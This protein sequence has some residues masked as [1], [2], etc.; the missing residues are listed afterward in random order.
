MAM[1]STWSATRQVFAFFTLL[2]LATATSR[3]VTLQ[4]PADTPTMT[5]SYPHAPDEPGWDG[6]F[7]D[8]HGTKL[9][10]GVAGGN[11][12]HSVIWAATTDERFID[13]DLDSAVV[14]DRVVVQSYKHYT[15]RDFQ[16]DHVRLYL[17]DGTQE[18]AGKL[19]GEQRGYKVADKQGMRDFVF[20]MPPKPV[21]RFRIGLRNDEPVRLGVSEIVVY[22]KDNPDI[23]YA[24]LAKFH[25]VAHV[26]EGP[27][28]VATA[29]DREAGY[30]LFAPNY[31]RRVFPNSVALAQERG[32]SVSLA[33]SLGEYEPLTVAIYPLEDLAR[34]R[35]RVTDL[36][37]PGEA[38]IGGDCVDVRTVRHL[39][40]IPGQK[41]SEYAKQYMIVPELLEAKATAEV[42]AQTTQQWW[43]TVRVPRDATPAEYAGDILVESAKGPVRRLGLRLRVLP[44]RL[45]LPKDHQFGMYW[46]PWRPGEDPVS[47]ERILAELRDMR[48][49]GMNSV[50][51][52]APASVSRA[53]SGRYEFDLETVTRALE[54]L[55]QEGLAQ[56]IPWAHTFP[57]VDTDF[58]SEEHLRQ[59]KA[60]VEH[61]GRDFAAR[62]L[63]EILWYPRDEAWSDPRKEEARVLYEAIKQVPGARTYGTVRRD[64][65]EYLDSWLDVRCHTVSLSGGFDDRKLCAAARTA[66][67]L[68]WWYTNACR[69]YPD[70]V[71]FKAG[72]FFW[73]T[74]ATGQFYWAYHSPQGNPYDDLDGI[75]WCVAYP[76]DGRPI[77]TIEWEALREGIDDFRYVYSLELAIAKARAK[78][79]AEAASVAE[80]AGRL[81]DELRDEIVSDL[82]EYERRGLNF[83][84]DSIWPAE[85]YDDWRK[86]IAR[87]IVRLQPLSPIP[88]TSPAGRS[89]P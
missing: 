11:A 20:A 8:P 14:L 42:K 74:G 24:V 54:L 18:K 31:L 49:H 28:P 53:E 81:L 77:P 69:E 76:G 23:S 36:V 55:K 84:T 60:F 2:L 47:E 72:F 1:G 21:R 56:P 5:Y 27:P 68:F 15:G 85:K 10:D 37:G 34:C 89:E 63:P 62:N 9:V 59:V 17:A 50:A 38:R 80:E 45:E 83:H 44:V 86:R 52:S 30:V 64:T 78:G 6:A 71:R 87:M 43:I 57:P 25:K 19:L 61:A 22:S 73:K 46:G 40:Q 35:V 39:R 48:E 41:G 70:V 3:A 33:A 32:Q 13:V 79:S 4:P 7:Q 65:A 67:D 16:L 29:E 12:R 26:P 51:L 88:K 82:E 58:G 66:G 75:D